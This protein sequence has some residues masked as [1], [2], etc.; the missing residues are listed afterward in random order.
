MSPRLP[1]LYWGELIYATPG[2]GKTFVA[3]KYRDV[4]DFDDLM[5]AA[6]KEVS[7]SGFVLDNHDDPREGIQKYF[8]YI[9]FSR[10]LMN[11]VYDH[12]MEMAHSHCENNDVVLLGTR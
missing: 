11:K 8:K 9:Q 1:R 3:N 10:R 6:I 2:T 4:I 5:I 7:S 12:A